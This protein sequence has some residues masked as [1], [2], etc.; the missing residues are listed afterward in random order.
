MNKYKITYNSMTAFYE[1][2][3]QYA[4]SKEEAERNARSTASAFSQ[5]EKSLIKATEVDH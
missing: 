2:G 4:D 5:G 1:M 3:F